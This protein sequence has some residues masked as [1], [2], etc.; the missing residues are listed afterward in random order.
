MWR[1][2]LETVQMLQK[3]PGHEVSWEQVFPNGKGPGKISHHT[4]FVQDSEVIFIGGLRGEDSCNEVFVFDVI[5]CCWD[6]C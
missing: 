4:A 1:L 5:Q 6:T 2:N 3:D